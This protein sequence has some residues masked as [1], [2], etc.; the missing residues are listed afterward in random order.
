MAPNPASDTTETPANVAPDLARPPFNI[1]ELTPVPNAN[2]PSPTTIKSM[3]VG[4]GYTFSSG[5]ARRPVDEQ[6]ENLTIGALRQVA[7][8]LGTPTDA[9]NR[10]KLLLRK[11]VIKQVNILGMIVQ[12]ASSFSSLPR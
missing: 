3:L 6:C 4:F 5:E 7:T 9:Q 2:T 10:N 1:A 12:E 11:F 8:H